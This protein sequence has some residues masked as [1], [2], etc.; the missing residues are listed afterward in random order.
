MSTENK[1][2]DIVEIANNYACFDLQFRQD[3]RHKRT[4]SPIYYRW[5]TQFIITISKDRIA[6]LNLIYA[7][8]DC[9]KVSISQNQARFSVQKIED[10]KEKIIPY[11]KKNSL[12]GKKKND[13]N[14]W[15]KAVEIIY[16]NKGKVFMSWKKNE[17][18]Q[19]IEIQKTALKYK[20]RPRQSK[21]Q[22]TAEELAKTL[23]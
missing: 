19:L 17:F 3:V 1:K 6:E 8:L 12:A 23:K 22:K 2:I 7:E 10:I 5:K 11:F 13:F 21:W 14:L 4:G 16:N 15:Q 9:G 20:E 18:L